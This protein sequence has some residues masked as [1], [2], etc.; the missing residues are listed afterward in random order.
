MCKLWQTDWGQDGALR[1][2]SNWKLTGVL[3]SGHCHRAVHSFYTDINISP[4]STKLH[5]KVKGKT[6]RVRVMNTCVGGGGGSVAPYILNRGSTHRWVGKSTLQLLCRRETTPMCGYQNRSCVKNLTRNLLILPG[7]RS[8]GCP[9]SSLVTILAELRRM[10]RNIK[11]L[12]SRYK[13]V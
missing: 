11:V 6:S 8:K 9:S 13:R 3:F 1:H 12:C 10:P 7:N 5:T 2:H 4:C